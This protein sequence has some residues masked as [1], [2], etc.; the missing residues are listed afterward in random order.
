[1]NMALFSF[2]FVIMIFLLIFK[3]KQ[4]VTELLLLWLQ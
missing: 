4:Q 3:R 2:L 1:M